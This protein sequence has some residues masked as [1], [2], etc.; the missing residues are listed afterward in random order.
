MHIHL[1]TSQSDHVQGAVHE[2]ADQGLRPVLG[3]DDIIHPVVGG[4]VLQ[5]SGEQ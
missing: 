3:G 4:D 2:A 1:F 5:C